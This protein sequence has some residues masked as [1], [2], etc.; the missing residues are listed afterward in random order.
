MDVGHPRCMSITRHLTAFVLAVALVGAATPTTAQATARGRL[1]DR[2]NHI[3]AVHG[4]PAVRPASQLRSAALLPTPRRTRSPSD[5]ARAHH[6]LP[7]RASRRLHRPR[8]RTGTSRKT[9]GSHRRAPHRHRALPRQRRHHRRK[10]QPERASTPSP[11]RTRTDRSGRRLTR[12]MRPAW[13]A[14]RRVP[15]VMVMGA[16]RNMAPPTLGRREIGG[17]GGTPRRRVG[18]RL[19]RKAIHGTRGDIYRRRTR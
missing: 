7:R 19:T 15:I 6:G 14:V 2:I 1:L 18:W 17:V 3:R 11:L 8:R 10:P 13:R 5:Q 4:L 16:D 9:C 12:A